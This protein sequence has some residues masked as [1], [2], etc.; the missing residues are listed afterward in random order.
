MNVLRMAAAMHG[1]LKRVLLVGCEPA[2]FGGEEGKIGLSAPVGA[3]VAEAA[4]VVTSLVEKML[5][6]AHQGT[7][8]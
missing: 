4:R 8:N 3:A 7:G 1:P 2:T 5:N 6:D